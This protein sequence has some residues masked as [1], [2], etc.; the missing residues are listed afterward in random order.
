MLIVLDFECEE[1]HVNERF[2]H[3][4]TQHVECKDCGARAYRKV[5]CPNFKL[6]GFTGDYPTAYDDWE[7]KR[8]QKLAEE[9]KRKES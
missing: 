2:V 7:R 5:S 8:K 4:E 6:E 3:H 1:G 9:R